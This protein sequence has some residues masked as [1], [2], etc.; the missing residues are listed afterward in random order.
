MIFDEATSAL[1]TKSEQEI[2]K[3]LEAIS[4]DKITI[5]I[6][7]RLKTI[8]KVDKIIVLKEGKVSCMGSKSELLKQ[9]DE[10][11]HLNGL[12]R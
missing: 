4:K 11:I 1:D 10:F 2:T 9:C 7:H 5:I 8:E 3:A 12:Q 6:A